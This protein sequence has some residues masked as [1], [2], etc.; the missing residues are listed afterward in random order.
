MISPE[1]AKV[2]RSRINC[3][4]LLCALCA[5]IT[6][7]PAL[8][9]QRSR[10]GSS[11][12]PASNSERSDSARGARD[13]QRGSLD[14]LQITTIATRPPVVTHHTMQL[15]GVPLRYTATTGMLPIR[16]DST[17]VAEGYIFYVAYTKDGVSDPASRPLTFTF[18]GGPGS[19]TVWLHMGAF[20]PRRVKL[21]SDGAAPPPP[22]EVEDN[23]FTLLDQTDLVFLDPVGTGYSRPATPK[24]GEKFWGLDQ[25]IAS[26][27]EFIRLYLTRNE[28]WGSPKFLAGESYGT[29]RAAGLSGYL[30]DQGIALNGVVLISTVLN[31]GTSAARKGNDIGFTRFLPTY[32]ATAWYHKKLPAD[33]QSKSLEEVTEEA[34]EWANT[35]YTLALVRGNVLSGAA[36]AAVVDTLARYT[37]LSKSFVDQNDLRISLSRFDQEL[38]R[39]QRLTVGRLD[40]RFTTYA[41]DA[42]AERGEFDPSEAGIRN[43]FTPVFN[44]YVRRELGFDDDQV[45]YILGGGIGRWQYPQGRFADV[46]PSLEHAFA[47]NPHM[48]LYVAMGYYDAATPYH[49]VQYT[50]DHLAISPEVRAANITADYFAAGHMIYIDSPSMEKMRKGLESFIVSA[51]GGR[52]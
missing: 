43:S 41:T 52:T 12:T 34:A 21:L 51:V 39:D 30:A 47:K 20:G 13:S 11:T 16:N 22:Y 10:S 37:G 1:H 14:S 33:L 49:A 8:A 23:P 29:T 44:D 5:A 9:A 42:G 45:Y 46:T 26:V 24:L 48:K 36:R 7:A 3:T 38:L 17:G 6:A 4:I 50:L 31:F 28:R 25:D 15:H 18:N 27:G 35:G 32:T 2:R 40:A 19:S